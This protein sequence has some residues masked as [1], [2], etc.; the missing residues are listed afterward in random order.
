M[1]QRK[2]YNLLVT[3]LG[4][5]AFKALIDSG[6]S[7]GTILTNIAHI[8]GL[9]TGNTKIQNSTLIRKAKVK[10]TEYYPE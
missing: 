5:V 9:G 1:S 8:D 3:F 10:F 2:V 6:D 7:V 4:I